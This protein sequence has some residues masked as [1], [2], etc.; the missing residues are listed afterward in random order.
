[1]PVKYPCGFCQRP[2][3]INSRAIECDSCKQWIHTKC[4]LTTPAEYNWLIEHPET[5]WSCQ[6]CNSTCFPFNE[7]SNEEL[8]LTMQGKNIDSF[9]LL[10]LDND[11]NI[12]LPRKI[13][14]HF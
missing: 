1:M 6:K 13:Q 8:K 14:L 2:V 3:A 7:Q 12:L 9:G 10:I 11:E 4:N 5:P